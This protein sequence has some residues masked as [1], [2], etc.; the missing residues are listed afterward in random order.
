LGDRSC[1][2]SGAVSAAIWASR[3]PSGS[4]LSASCA[5]ELGYRDLAM[6]LHERYVV[7]GARVE[8]LTRE[9]AAALSAVV[10]DMD[11]AGIP[12]RAAR[13]AHTGPGTQIAGR[14]P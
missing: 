2:S 9:L 8:D 1:L 12:R 7:N 5:R 6:Y 13:G 4:A 14:R 11:R 3:E 10:A